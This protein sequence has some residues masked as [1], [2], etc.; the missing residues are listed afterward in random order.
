MALKNYAHHR[1]TPSAA[2]PVLPDIF[3]MSN[4]KGGGLFFLLRRHDHDHLTT[5]HLGKLLDGG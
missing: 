1:M 5:F 3:K 4:G 2:H